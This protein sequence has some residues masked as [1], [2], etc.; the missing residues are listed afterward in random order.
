[1]K[2][3]KKKTT[4]A[5]ERA[6]R[7]ARVAKTSKKSKAAREALAGAA[8]LQRNADAA[9]GGQLDPKN[10]RDAE[11]LTAREL[12]IE[13]GEHEYLTKPENLPEGAK[14]KVLKS[15][16][17]QKLAQPV[18]VVTLP[19]AEATATAS[20]PKGKRA[21]AARAP[22]ATKAWAAQSVDGERARAVLEKLK[23]GTREKPVMAAK[24]LTDNERHFARILF[25]HGL[26]QRDK[27]EQGLGYFAQ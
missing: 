19:D 25:A 24:Q 7:E 14:V 8:A 3:S 23:K 1:M 15:R 13:L 2:T 11:I 17:G 20:A 22:E 12:G 16:N 9:A 10:P 27:F 21:K 18:Y 6:A 26:I 5:D 4:A